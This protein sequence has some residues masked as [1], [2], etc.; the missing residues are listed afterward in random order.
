MLELVHNMFLVALVQP[1]SFL[2][3]LASID[4]VYNLCAAA[5]RASASSC[6]GIACAVSLVIFLDAV[7]EWLYNARRTDAH[8]LISIAARFAASDFNMNV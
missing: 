5:C 2:G 8:F 6:A 4:S 3:L 7:D 1:L